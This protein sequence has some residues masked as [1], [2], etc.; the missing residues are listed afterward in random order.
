MKILHVN[1]IVGLGGAA[2]ICLALHRAALAAGHQSAVLVGR[3][4]RE[5][6]GVATLD[7]DRYRPA[8]GRFWMG[9][10]RRLRQYS[11][12]IPGVFR[13]SEHWLPRVASPARFRSWREG[14]EDFDFPGT[15][16]LLEQGPFAPEVLHLHNLH[17]DYFDLRE[18]PRLSRAVPTIITLH[19]TWMLT[20]H[21]AYFLGCERW[22]SGCG[23]CPDLAVYP[24]VRCDGTAANWRRK[25]D[26][27]KASR[28]TLVCPARWLA[29]RVRESMLL[30]AATRLEVIP[31]G[32]DT[33][34]F[35]PG[36]KEDARLRLGWPADAFIA[37]FVGVAG[38]NSFYKDFATM[39]EAIRQMA[40]ATSGPPVRL[41]VV[42]E[43]AEP[44]QLG[45]ARIEF[46]SYRESIA[47]CYQAADVYLHAAKIDTF[48]TTVLEALACGVPVAATAVGGIPEQVLDGETGFLVPA[49]D[50]PAMADRLS[51]LERSPGLLSAMGAAAR[52]DA[53]ERFTLELMTSR[54]E[55]LYRA[56]GER[57]TG[58]HGD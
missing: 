36:S 38:R 42:G 39:R 7:N 44:E 30:P 46:L 56:V 14:H 16:Q 45:G 13:L 43:G 33:T 5:M 17:G 50:A 35:Q 2:G 51:R 25:Q 4:S 49:G 28:L 24:G 19:D 55:R 48:P 41:Y 12:R 54:Y 53:Q 15:G 18:L 52:R 20:G 21:C 9:A 32:V 3:R 22:K 57:K 27:F 10:A 34:I 29:D 58:A 26:I 40:H 11:G 1:Q 31:N 47:D 6:P 23:A 8:W 37:L